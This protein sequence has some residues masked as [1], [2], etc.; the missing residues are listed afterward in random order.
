MDKMISELAAEMTPDMVTEGSWREV[1]EIIGMVNLI[2]VLEVIG[3]TTIYAPKPDTILRPIRD[4]QI[5]REFNGYNHLALAKKY[6]LSERYMRSLLGNGCLPD[7]ISL[8]ETVE[9]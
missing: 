3:G 9:T 2:K 5:K 6:N 1:A 7:Q 4:V 8:F